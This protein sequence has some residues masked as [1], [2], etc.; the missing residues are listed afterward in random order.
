MNSSYYNS[1]IFT[2]DIETYRVE[3]DA[4]NMLFE[5]A[6][7]DPTAR[8]LIADLTSGEASAVLGRLM[9]VD[10]DNAMNHYEFYYGITL[11]GVF[12]FA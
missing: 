3:W 6:K 4:H 10:L 1:S 7:T 11:K 2:R 12:S 5:I 9:S 8:R